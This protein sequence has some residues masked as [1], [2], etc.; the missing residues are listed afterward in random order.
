MK[1]INSVTL[2]GRLTRDAEF[3]LTKN[4]TPLLKF[5][6]ASSLDKEKSGFFDCTIWGKFAESVK[7]YLKKG[8][9]LAIKGRLN[10]ESWEKDGKKQS[11]VSIVADAVQ[12]LGSKSD[13]AQPAAP[14][15][16]QDDLPF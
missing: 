5:S 16:N 4:D 1:D 9:Q 15:A 13:A 12:L 14:A 8:K 10:W 2:V 11:K 7:D 6:L 3:Q